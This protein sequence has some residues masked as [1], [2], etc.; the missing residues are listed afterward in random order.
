M[1]SLGRWVAACRHSP[2]HPDWGTLR[3]FESALWLILSQWVLSFIRYARWNYVAHFVN[4][5]LIR[6]IVAATFEF[7][8]V[9]TGWSLE[10]YLDV[11][12]SSRFQ[13]CTLW[14]SLFVLFCRHV[15]FVWTVNME[16]T[17]SVVLPFTVRKIF[18]ITQLPE[19][20]KRGSYGNNFDL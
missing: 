5:L 19:E 14:I 1:K 4:P 18:F 16:E 13:I 9:S 11:V 12:R 7:Y 17:E 8:S 20:R 10:K 2:S 6:Q 3:P 15:Q